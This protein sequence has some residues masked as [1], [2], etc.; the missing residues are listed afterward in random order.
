MRRK[1]YPFLLTIVFLLFSAPSALAAGGAGQRPIQEVLLLLGIVAVAYLVSHL[2]VNQV[3]KRFGFISGVEFILL[4]AIIGP[5]LGLLNPEIVERFRLAIF[6]AT[7]SLG[8]LVG[9]EIDFKNVLKN[10]DL[11]KTALLI[12][13]TT[14]SIVVGLPTLLIYQLALDVPLWMPIILCAGANSLVIDASG[15]DAMSSFL[16]AKGTASDLAI[17]ITQLNSSLSIICF[18]LIFCFYNPGTSQSTSNF[19]FGH[20]LL[21]HLSLGLI[22]G[23]IFSTFLRKDF[24]DEKLLTIVLGIVVFSSGLASYLRL[25]PIFVNF[26]LGVTLINT[27]RNGN[28]V[29]MM[30]A[31]LQRPFY[32]ILFFFAG[33]SW[34][35]IAPWWAYLL[36]IPFL[37]LRRLGHTLGVFLALHNSPL[38][39]RLPGLER[40][41]LSMGGLSIAMT[42]N[43]AAMYKTLALTPLIYSTLLISI[44]LNEVFAPAKMRAWLIDAAD[45]PTKRD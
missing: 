28:Q 32:I 1:F 7:G 8:L 37:L 43:F 13:I 19:T 40:A 2:L 31:S 23:L 12:S 24:K 41:M 6:L 4:G 16:K 11:V 25:S 45:I 44:I 35:F 38:S 36:F 33:L 39:G 20:W 21:I 17:K 22:L 14:L 9:L 15:L 26:I 3:A 42:L 29:E 30:L 34:V 27:C 18:G 10:L 5:G